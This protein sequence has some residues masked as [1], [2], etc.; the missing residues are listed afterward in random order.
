[1]M[2]KVPKGYKQTE[3]GVIPEWEVKSLESLTPKGRKYCIVDGPFGS[4]NMKDGVIDKSLLDTK[5]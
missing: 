1:M 4:N 2:S 3:V 5:K